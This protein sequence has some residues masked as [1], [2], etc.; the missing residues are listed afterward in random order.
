MPIRGPLICR[1]AP[2]VSA[3]LILAACSPAPPSKT[4]ALP[5]LRADVAF[6][7][8]WWS[9]A[10]MKGL[11]PNA[12]PP[13]SSMVKLTKWEYSDPVGVPHPDTVNVVVMLVNNEGQPLS[14]LEVEL[15][16]EWK[17]GPLRDGSTAAWSSE[18]VLKKLQG[19]FIGPSGSRTV[20]VPVEVKAMMDSLATKG[21][22]PYALRVRVKVHLPGAVQ[23]LAQAEA[24]LPIRPGD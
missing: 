2:F 16:G 8:V 22:W 23:L 19:V 1:S 20:S 9:E 14:N 18:T 5:T 15:T 24:E 12:P 13:K 7:A 3:L 10:Q 11:N 4:S 21:D 17:S 6:T